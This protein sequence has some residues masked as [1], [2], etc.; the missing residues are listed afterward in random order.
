M[1]GQRIEDKSVFGTQATID[2]YS[3]IDFDKIHRCAMWSIVHT[4]SFIL[5]I[6]V[7]GKPQLT[8]EQFDER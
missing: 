5:S 6:A 4:G 3:W 2:T 1:S 8:R 7:A